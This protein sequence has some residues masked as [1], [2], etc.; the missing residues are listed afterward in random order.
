MNSK[1]N[2][3]LTQIKERDLAATGGPWSA[4]QSAAEGWTAY[5]IVDGYQ[6]AVKYRDL[7]R[8]ND[9]QFIAHAREDVPRL[10]NIVKDCLEFIGRLNLTERELEL[11]YETINKRI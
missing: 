8:T 1:I 5:S 2:T 10:T 6:R 4:K 9:A 7:I 3:Y 11:L